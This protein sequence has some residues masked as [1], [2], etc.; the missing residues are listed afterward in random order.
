MANISLSSLVKGS[1]SLG[2]TGSRGFTGSFGFSG[3]RGYTGSQGFVGSAGPSAWTPIANAQMTI[4]Q[5]N[6]FI[7]TSGTNGAFDGQVY[8]KEGYVTAAV[9]AY[10]SGL[11]QGPNT[12][13]GLT[14]N[15]TSTSTSSLNYAFLIDYNYVKVQELGNTVTLNQLSPG[16]TGYDDVNNTFGPIS[17]GVTSLQIVYDGENVKYYVDTTLIRSVARSS[18][19]MLYFSSFF[20]Y[21]NQTVPTGGISHVTFGAVGRNGYTGS[22]GSLGYTGSIGFTGSAGAGFTGSAGAGFTGSAGTAGSAGTTGFTGSVGFTGSA[23]AGFT[24]SAGTAGSAGTTG[25]TG[26]VGFTGSAGGTGFTGSIGFTGSGSTGFTG[27]AG[28]GFTGSAGTVG[29]TGS[30]G[31]G[32]TSTAGFTTW[33]GVPYDIG[34]AVVG[35]PT[36]SQNVLKFRTVRAFT[37]GTTGHMAN[38]DVAATASTT[39]TIY[40]NAGSIGSVVFGAGATTSTITIASTSFA[41]G[42][43]FVITAP[44]S[45]DSTLSDIDFSFF[46][47][48]N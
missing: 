3:S 33:T 23:G 36:A 42:D 28:A 26:S 47:T 20:A 24:G 13:F 10:M 11:N 32:L 21:V 8:S 38:A 46:A 31:G 2:F 19:S 15:T 17:G 9:S 45:I 25:F 43:K 30:A 27:S 34:S 44:A 14:T 37:I 4:S 22:T 35:K 5:D 48:L 6:T 12:L 18:S 40:K 7:K 39:F 29:F 16:T 41:A 1:S